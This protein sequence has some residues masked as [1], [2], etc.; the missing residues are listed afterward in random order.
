MYMYQ[1]LGKEGRGKGEEEEER[2][3]SV[4]VVF[5]CLLCSLLHVHALSCCLCL[6]GCI[7]SDEVNMLSQLTQTCTQTDTHFMRVTELLSLMY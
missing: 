4:G 7:R 3:R 5:N 1:F 2:G 6:C